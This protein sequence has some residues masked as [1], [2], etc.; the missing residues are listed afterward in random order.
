[1]TDDRKQMLVTRARVTLVEL[2]KTILELQNAGVTVDYSAVFANKR[3][4]HS[5]AIELRLEFSEITKVVL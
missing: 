5:D 4:A 2:N 3:G 1:M